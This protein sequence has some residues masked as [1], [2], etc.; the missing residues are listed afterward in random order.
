MTNYLLST[1][2]FLP[3]LAIVFILLSPR[4]NKK[5]AF[6]ISLG[7]TISQLIIS[8]FLLFNK[9]ASNLDGLS[10]F[11]K[12][13][14]ISMSF[15]DMGKLSIDYFLGLDGFNLG[16]FVLAVFIFLIA[17][18]ASKN[19]I[20]E[21]R[22][23][24][25]A[26]LLLLNTTV[27]GCFASLDFFLF[28]LFFEF[29][30]IPM[31]FLIGMWGGSNKESAALKF[32]LYTLVGSLFI[33][34][35]MIFLYTST[36]DPV[37]T[38]IQI[39][40]IK[41]KDLVSPEIINQVQLMLKDG[42]I[43]TKDYVRTFN[44]IEMSDARNFIP[45]SLLTDD[46]AQFLGVSLRALTFLFLF[47][48]FAI[49]LPA[50]PFHTWLPDAHV[51][52]STPISVLLA[53]LLLKIG[54]YGLIRT[55]YSILPDMAI[56]YS[57]MIGILG[58]ASILYGAFNALAMT[59]LKKLIAY[60][61]VSHMGFVLLGLASFTAEGMNGAIFQMISHGLISALLFL[62]VGV[63]YARVN[64]RDITN[65][66]GLAQLMPHFTA[67][68]I[69]GFFASMG[70]P[71]FSG[72]IAELLVL[73][74]AFTSEGTNHLLPRWIAIVSSLGLILSAGYYLWT[75]KRMFFGELKLRKDAWKM[76]L[77]DLSKTEYLIFTPLI[78][79]IILFGIFPNIILDSTSDS[80]LKLVDV[81]SSFFPVK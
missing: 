15:G 14:W 50:I 60:S 41:N 54:G 6:N 34:I 32:L 53:S 29:M 13:D 4:E 81:A 68:V 7:A 35:A 71:G 61:S 65:F 10:Y 64:N 75:L 1:I 37:E 77:S 69:I 48:G 30:L 16:L 42:L 17:V 72:F 52:A 40:L 23:V 27:L 74:G 67:V 70:L 46:T 63:I 43:S 49:K 78:A 55:A 12:K 21:K 51:E 45:N 3:I 5:L 11:E 28:F 19:S 24:Y 9:S 2:I 47:L 73:L 22:R 62:I 31:Y 18:L 76:E 8:A 39:G 59:D 80:V 66:S 36:L 58:M 44:L 57:Y 38:A 33:L 79:L 56:E 20:L 25:Y 26:L